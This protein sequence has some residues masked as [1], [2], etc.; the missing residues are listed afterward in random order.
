MRS[1]IDDWR[2]E[3]D[4]FWATTGRRVARRNLVVSV[5]TEPSGCR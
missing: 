3:D 4:E 2:P 5:L 1:W